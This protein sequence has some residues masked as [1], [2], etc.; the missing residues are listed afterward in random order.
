[1]RAFAF[2]QF[3]NDDHVVLEASADTGPAVRGGAG[4]AARA[5]RSV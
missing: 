2:L 5:L 3:A 1:V 4:V